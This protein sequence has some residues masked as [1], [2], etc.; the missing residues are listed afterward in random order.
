YLAIYTGVVPQAKQ[1]DLINKLMNGE[2]IKATLS[3]L[4]Y[5]VEVMANYNEE[6]KI[7]LEKQLL[8]TFSPM[9]EEGKTTTLW[10]TADGA[11]AF[12]Y[13]GS[14]CHGWSAILIYFYY[15]YIFQLKHL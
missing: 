10:E 2:F 5:I 14:M 11:A 1:A 8:N 13:S 6:T 15:K 9:L 4:F 12:D 3:S 7:Y